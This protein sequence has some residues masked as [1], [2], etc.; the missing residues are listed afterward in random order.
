[1]KEVYVLIDYGAGDVIYASE[2]FT[3]VQEMMYEHYMD[4]L[5]YE[6]LWRVNYDGMSAS[7]AY[8]SVKNALDPWY[9]ETIVIE[10]VILD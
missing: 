4:M 8:T 3:N 2:N 6:F 7:D 1:M 9:R 5:Y 10:K